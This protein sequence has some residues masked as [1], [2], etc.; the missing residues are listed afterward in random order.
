M[1]KTINNILTV[2][3]LEYLHFKCKNFIKNNETIPDGK[4]W[5]Y[6][7]MHLDENEL[8]ELRSRVSDIVGEN[9]EIQSN[10][11]FI[12]KITPETN[13]NDYYHVDSC[14]LTIVIYL[15]DNFEGGEF[16][17]IQQ[18]ETHKIKPY[19]NLSI[20]MDREIPHRALSIQNGERYSLIIWFKL[21]K[22]PFL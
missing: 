17:Y 5:F 2:T 20:M 16:E 8:I 13:L 9:Y 12:N 7:S 18:N 11:I 19:T 14:D 15:N 1:I 4:L 22:K 6:N 21:T 10:G 3:E